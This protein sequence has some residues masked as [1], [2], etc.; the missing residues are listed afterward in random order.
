MLRTPH[1][2]S[3]WLCRRARLAN[4]RIE[5]GLDAR[6]RV[7]SSTKRQET[8]PADGLRCASFGPL[9]T[10]RKDLRRWPDLARSTLMGDRS[11]HEEI[12]DEIIALSNDMAALDEISHG[13]VV[14]A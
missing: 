9:I 14:V 4:S 10:A 1:G 3:R 6:A 13:T 8:S 7:R 5:Q 2:G 12:M 11:S